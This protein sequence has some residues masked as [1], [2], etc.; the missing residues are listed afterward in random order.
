MGKLIQRSML[1]LPVHV[2]KYV[3]KACMREADAILLDMEDAV[4]PAEKESARHAVK[5]SIRLAGRGGAD[6]LVRINN[7]KALWRAD[8]DSA[9]WP[10]LH[11]I[12]IP[13]VESEAG[14]AKVDDELTRLESERGFEPGSVMLALHIESPLGILGIREILS[15]G[16]RIESVSIGVDDYCLEL[17]VEPSEN[18]DELF[19]AFSTMV[20]ASKAMG[21]SPIGVLGTV[22]NYQDLDGFRR[23]AERGRQ[24]G[25]EGAYCVHPGQVAVLNEVYTP[26]PE[27]VAYSRR[28]KEAFE[29]GIKEGR[30]TVSLDGRMVDPPIYKRAVL[31]VERADAI[32]QREKLKAEALEK[33][34]D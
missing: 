24:M 4:P 26:T 34:K 28:V 30:A 5:E 6:V 23:A 21:I 31:I 25:A 29:A 32:A 18:A 3:E 15:V 2:K 14:V 9:V 10:G 1:I 13:K 20:L 16:S 33:I 27:R 11:G 12:F 22:A 8:L 17:G 7:E 19:L